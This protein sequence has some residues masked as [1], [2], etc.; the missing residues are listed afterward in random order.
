MTGL[1]DALTAAVE[2]V[3]AIERV[4]ARPERAHADRELAG[5]PAPPDHSKRV[6]VAMRAQ[7]LTG[8]HSA[9]WEGQTRDHRWINGNHA[10]L[11][12]RSTWVDLLHDQRETTKPVRSPREHG[13]GKRTATAGAP[14]EIVDR[15]RAEEARC[16]EPRRRRRV[17]ERITQ[18]IG[19][20]DRH[21]PEPQVVGR[22]DLKLISL[23]DWQCLDRNQLRS[24]GT[25]ETQE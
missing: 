23:G 7:I 5:G 22:E 14:R 4:E 19:E 18:R 10:A 20:C 11:V 15:R 16:A 21:T 1:H 9:R 17:D 2:Q 25:D 24:G 3:N 8:Q 12:R 13:D 6:L